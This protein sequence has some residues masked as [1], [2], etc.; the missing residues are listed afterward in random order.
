MNGTIKVESIL[1]EATKFI[2]VLPL[3]EITQQQV[4]KVDKQPNLERLDLTINK[5]RVLVAEDNKANQAIIKLMLERQGHDVCIVSHGEEAILEIT[6]DTLSSYDLILMD[7]SMPIKDRLT[8]TKELRELGITLPIIAHAM[9]SEK[10]IYLDSGIDD[11]SS[12]LI[13]AIE[14]K[15]Y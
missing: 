4:I 6:K 15:N 14:L 13:R 8:A 5:I 2:V 7:I 11:F 3:K 1:N 12:K 9:N 10:K